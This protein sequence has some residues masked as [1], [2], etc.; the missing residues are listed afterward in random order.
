LRVKNLPKAII[1]RDF[2]VD[3]YNLGLNTASYKD[4]VL[5]NIFSQSLAN[6]LIGLDNTKPIK[7]NFTATGVK[8][9]Y[10]LEG[11]IEYRLKGECSRC[12]KVINK[13]HQGKF[14]A[15]FTDRYNESKDNDSVYE[16]YGTQA[17]LTPLIIDTVGLSLDYK[18]LCDENC[19][20]LCNFCGEDLNKT[21]SH[22]H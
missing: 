2:T 1:N 15:F 22:K 17:D 12:L 6:R 18:P 5:E 10:Y 19:Q 21:T 14:K 8:N 3:L 20:G 16:L 7:L 13:I 11:T 4:F 9:G